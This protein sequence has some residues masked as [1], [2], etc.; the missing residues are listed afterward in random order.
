VFL[1]ENSRQTHADT[2][3]EMPEFVSGIDN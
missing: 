2:V 3:S 1:T